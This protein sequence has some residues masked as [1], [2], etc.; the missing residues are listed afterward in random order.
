MSTKTDELLNAVAL[1]VSEGRDG[2]WDKTKEAFK[3]IHAHHLDDYDW[4]LKS[5]DGN[6]I[7]EAISKII[8]TREILQ[9]QTRS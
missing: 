4:F 6:L 1:N 9:L 3:Y 2:L 7:F 5:D 8:I